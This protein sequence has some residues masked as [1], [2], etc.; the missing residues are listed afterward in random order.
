MP[1]TDNNNTT[2]L[3]NRLTRLGEAQNALDIVK[4]RLNQIKRRAPNLKVIVEGGL[5][6]LDEAQAKIDKEFEETKRERW[7]AKD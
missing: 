4:I 2:R 3:E 6:N 1:N 5:D 7:P